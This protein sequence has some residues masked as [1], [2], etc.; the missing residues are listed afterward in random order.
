MVMLVAIIL[1][2]VIGTLIAMLLLFFFEDEIMD[3]LDS[4]RDCVR[5]ALGLD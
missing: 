4:L 2:W 3:L 5:K 1:G